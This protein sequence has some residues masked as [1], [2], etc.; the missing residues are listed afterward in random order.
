[1]LEVTN[2][3]TAMWAAFFLASSIPLMVIRALKLKKS[4]AAA[5]AATGKGK[6]GGEKPGEGGEIW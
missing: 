2:S 6:R 4:S 5:A 1:M 3:L